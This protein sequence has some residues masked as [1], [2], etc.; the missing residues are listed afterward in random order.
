MASLEQQLKGLVRLIERGAGELVS[1]WLQIDFKDAVDRHCAWF[2]AQK[3]QKQI[4]FAKFKTF[5]AHNYLAYYLVWKVSWNAQVKRYLVRYSLWYPVDISSPRRVLQRIEW[6]TEGAPRFSTDPQ[7]K[8]YT[9]GLSC[10]LLKRKRC[11][12]RSSSVIWRTF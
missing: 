9:N 4:K 8:F 12:P 2:S 1:D 7:C 10:V 6:L 11:R 5:C 3:R